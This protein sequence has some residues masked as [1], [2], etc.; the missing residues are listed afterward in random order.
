MYQS[1]IGSSG[2]KG[3][4]GFSHRFTSWVAND[5][6]IA[7][8]R[9][10]CTAS[11][12]RSLRNRHF[13]GITRWYAHV[14]AKSIIK[15]MKTQNNTLERDRESGLS[16]NSDEPTWVTKFRVQRRVRLVSTAS[17]HNFDDIDVTINA[18]INSGVK[19]DSNAT[20][21][22]NGSTTLVQR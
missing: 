16:M 17:G 4:C 10:V 7:V 12:S 8:K 14:V 2:S 5:E 21:V 18:S 1:K 20:F 15:L 3:A 19:Q 11:R 13:S 9:I 22:V 6:A